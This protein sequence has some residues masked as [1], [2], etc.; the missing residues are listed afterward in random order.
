MGNIK[1]AIVGIGNCVSSLI[2]GIHYY[3]EKDPEDASGLMH[4]DMN[5]YKPGDIEVVAAFDIDR[6]KV[7]RDVHEA[8]FTKPNCTTLFCPDLPPSGV[9]VR[10]GKIL[11]GVAGHMKDYPDDHAF[12]LSDAPEPTAA[13]IIQVI[14]E[15][16]AQILTNYLPVGS[17]DATRFYPQSAW[18]TLHRWQ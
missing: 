2:Q 6:R 11:D 18:P 4:Y 15:S 16:G 10:M 3:R 12:V 9:T 1:I 8:I 5:G 7:G 17:E 14:K 13:E